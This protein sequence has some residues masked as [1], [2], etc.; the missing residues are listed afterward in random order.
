MPDIFFNIVNQK[1]IHQ[2]MITNLLDIY[3]Y[4][5]SDDGDDGFV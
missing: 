1:F 2:E 4:I 5:I 3:V